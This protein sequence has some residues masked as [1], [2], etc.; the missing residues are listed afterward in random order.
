MSI[1]P[2][3]Q[4]PAMLVADL[5]W[6][7]SEDGPNVLFEE[8]KL[9][10]DFCRDGGMEA[11]D[12]FLDNAQ[13]L[14]QELRPYLGTDERSIRQILSAE[15]ET[16]TYAKQLKQSDLFAQMHEDTLDYFRRINLSPKNLKT[17]FDAGYYTGIIGTC[18]GMPDCG[19]TYIHM[20]DG[21]CDVRFE[22]SAGSLRYVEFYPFE[23]VD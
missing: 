23:L 7:D 3:H 15:T 10:V 20:R 19:S 2:T 6:R 5:D 13:L 8:T 16:A 4:I 22:I 12:A 21:K 17:A 18:C 1:L 14:D 11:I 9:G